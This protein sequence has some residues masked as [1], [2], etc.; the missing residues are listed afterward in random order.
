MSNKCE[1]AADLLLVLLFNLQI[2][3]FKC[4]KNFGVMRYFIISGTI[5]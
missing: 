5:N 1:I 3:T 4:F 2:C